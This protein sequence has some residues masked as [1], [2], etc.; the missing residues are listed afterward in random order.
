MYFNNYYNKTAIIMQSYNVLIAK[1]ITKLQNT[2]EFS[3][4]SRFQRIENNIFK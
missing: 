3:L 4:K 1:Y 2:E